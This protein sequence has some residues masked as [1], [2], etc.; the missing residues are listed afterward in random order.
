MPTPSRRWL[1]EVSAP[2]PHPG[3]LCDCLLART[4]CVDYGD[5]SYA[6]G[7]WHQLEFKATRN[8]ITMTIDGKLFITSRQMEFTASSTFYIGGKKKGASSA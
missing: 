3:V 2:S 6:D 7:L 8:R 1:A 5:G 4:P